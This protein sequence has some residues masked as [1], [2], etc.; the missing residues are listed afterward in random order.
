KYFKKP[1]FYFGYIDF[2]N[3]IMDFSDIIITKGGGITISE[4]LSKGLATII[5]NPIPGQEE[6]NVNFLL[7]E[8]AVIREDNIFKIGKKVEMLLNDE[9]KL[10]YFKQ[11][12]R[13]LSCND[14]SIR[15][16]DLVLKMI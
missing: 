7:S 14:S 6:R 8:G 15:I 12:A 2:V 11:K 3:K 16:A 9:N 13:F 10:N 4:A 5:T 1:L